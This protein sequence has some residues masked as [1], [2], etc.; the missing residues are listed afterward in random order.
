MYAFVGA[1]PVMSRSAFAGSAVSRAPAPVAS[2]VTMKA[3]KAIPFLEAPEKL[4]E[5]KAGCTLVV[6]VQTVLACFGG[7]LDL[8]E[9][10]GVLIRG[11]VGGEKDGLEWWTVKRL[12][13]GNWRSARLGP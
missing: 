5:T 3:S 11:G 2:T 12:R 13:A 1:T 8:C 6:T 10:S 4:D 9:A 7:G